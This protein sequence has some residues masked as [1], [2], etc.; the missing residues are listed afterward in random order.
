M[1]IPLEAWDVATKIKESAGVLKSMAGALLLFAF[2]FL[3]MAEITDYQIGSS[4]ISGATRQAALQATQQA[5]VTSSTA[6]SSS[7]ASVAVGQIG[8]GASGAVVADASETAPP[9][10]VSSSCNIDYLVEIS[11]AASNSQIP[12]TSLSSLSNF[13]PPSNGGEFDISRDGSGFKIRGNDVVGV[14]YILEGSSNLKDWFAIARNIPFTQDLEFN[15]QKD[16]RLEFAY[17]RVRAER[18]LTAASINVAALVVSD[19][20]PAPNTGGGGTVGS[21][22]ITEPGVT[23]IVRSSGGK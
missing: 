10:P 14:G 7:G 8:A 18:V 12:Q 4:W 11:A 17:L 21:P 23:G 5:A 22:T 3:G 2:T 16:S 15:V 9:P 20:T 19:L 1:T 6:A 13:S